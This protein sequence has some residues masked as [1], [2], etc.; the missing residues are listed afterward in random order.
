M[1]VGSFRQR[2]QTPPPAKT[3]WEPSAWVR[4]CVSPLA[5]SRC[6]VQA[7]LEGRCWAHKAGNG[8]RGTGNEK[9]STS[10]AVIAAHLA[11]VPHSPFPV[12]R[13]LTV[14]VT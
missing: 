9:A 4:I 5:E 2:A 12:P 11:L 6:M 3:F 8:A 13:M 1:V 7:R 10:S 14:P